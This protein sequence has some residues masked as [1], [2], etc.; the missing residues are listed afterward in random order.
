MESLYKYLYK[1]GASEAE[2]CPPNTHTFPTINHTA[3]KQS[4]AILK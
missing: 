3:K 2:E 4:K 1:L